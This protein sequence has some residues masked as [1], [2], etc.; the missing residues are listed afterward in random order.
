MAGPKGAL[1]ATFKITRAL[2]DRFAPRHHWYDCELHQSDGQCRRDSTASFG[3]Y[4]KHR[5]SGPR[6]A[7]AGTPQ[8]LTMPQVCIAVLYCAITVI[9]FLDNI[10]PHLSST[11]IDGLFPDRLG[12]RGRYCWQARQLPRL[13]SPQ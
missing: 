9:L 1:A 10:L 6:S 4:P 7:S 13:Q 12:C 5:Q 8:M 11:G 2:P 3:R